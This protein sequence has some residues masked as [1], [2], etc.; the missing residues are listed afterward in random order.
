MI[1]LDKRYHLVFGAATAA[2]MVLNLYLF[3][4]LG[5]AWSAMAAA[6]EVGIGYELVQKIRKEGTPDVT[7]AVA[8]IVGGLLVVFPLI[9]LGFKL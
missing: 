1:P 4:L 3:I 8:V 7:D 9:L 6:A 2:V 5:W